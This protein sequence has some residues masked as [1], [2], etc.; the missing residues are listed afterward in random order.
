MSLGERI[1]QARK[2]AGLTQQQVGDHFGI[3][4]NAVS[5]WE[6]D[7]NAPTAARIED[8]AALLQVSYAWL[9]SGQGEM[10]M[11]PGDPNQPSPRVHRVRDA[12]PAT[13]PTRHQMP[14]NLPVLGVTVGGDGGDFERNG[15]TIDYLLRPP[16]LA[17]VRDAFALYVMSD[18][19]WPRFAHGETV[20]VHPHR[21]ARP[22][23]DVVVELK[24]PDGEPI[25]CYL[26]RLVR[27]TAKELVLEQFNPRKE[28]P[29]PASKVRHVYRIL[30]PNELLGI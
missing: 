4:R 6:S 15:Q 22:G 12:A 5:L 25:P 1:A 27:R 23:D 2:A 7:E 28:I 24:A 21:P 10:H 26:K 30:T 11:I 13:L 20:F 8:L 18:S 29:I 9:G 14:Q 3:T 16:G 17:G 19:M